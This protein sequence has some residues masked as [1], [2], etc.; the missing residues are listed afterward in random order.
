MLSLAR[1]RAA[2]FK[3][4]ARLGRARARAHSN[5]EEFLNYRGATAHSPGWERRKIRFD[6]RRRG[7]DPRISILQWFYIQPGARRKKKYSIYV[8][9][10]KLRTRLQ[11]A[12]RSEK[13]GK[14]KRDDRHFFLLYI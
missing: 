12:I 13:M 3:A 4:A 6:L 10:K 11:R 7:R 5:T 14:V 9:T 2:I 1:I 8:E